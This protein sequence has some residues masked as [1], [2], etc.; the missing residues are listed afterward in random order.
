MRLRYALIGL[1][2]VVCIILLAPARLLPAAL[3]DDGPTRLTGVRGSVWNGAAAVGYGGQSLGSLSWKLDAARLAR[4]EAVFDWR[5]AGD[6]HALTGSA[7]LGRK[8]L[9]CD[10]AGAVHNATMRRILAPYW[11]EAEGDIGIDQ[12]AA[13]FD[14]EL[15]PLEVVGKLSWI[16]GEVRYRLGGEQYR[17][18]LPPLSGVL[19]TVDARPAL[20]VFGKGVD[21]PLLQ[22]R[23]GDDGWVDIGVTKMLTRMAGFPWPGTEADHMIVIE[24]SERLI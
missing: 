1:V 16:G 9:H 23:L 19:G 5:L 18:V 2:F 21:A 7:R 8:G 15:H 20:T 4:G 12:L 10:V 14:Y 17:V 22:I 24:L 13:R 11:I 3:G 6:G